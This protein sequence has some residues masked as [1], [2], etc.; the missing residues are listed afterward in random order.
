MKTVDTI[1]GP[2]V[3][4]DVDDITLVLQQD[5]T[6]DWHLAPYMDSAD[7]N[8]WAIDIGANIGWFTVYLASRFQ[9]VLAVE[10]HP[11]TA[12]LLRQNV[13][14]HGVSGVVDIIPAAADDHYGMVEPA[15]DVIHGYKTASWDDLNQHPHAAGLSLSSN[16]EHFHPGHDWRLPTIRVDDY[17]PADVRVTLIKLD[18]QGSALR[19]LH[20]LTRTVDRC[21]PRLLIEWEPEASKARGDDWTAYENFLTFHGYQWEPI[22]S[23]WNEWV[24]DPV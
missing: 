21:H 20:G 7:P 6:W 2:F 4:W 11:E 3:A 5:R 15:N 9:R 13:R 23:P 16:P 14:Q 17:V 19:A 8:G 12:R 10:A 22:N 1:Q 24:C 18:C